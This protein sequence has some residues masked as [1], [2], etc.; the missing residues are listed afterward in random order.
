[1]KSSIGMCRDAMIHLATSLLPHND[2][3]IHHDLHT[4]QWKRINASAIWKWK[5]KE[6]TLSDSNYLK[7]KKRPKDIRVRQPIKRTQ[8]TSVSF[9][10]FYIHW[11]F[12][13]PVSPQ[14]KIYNDIIFITL[15]QKGIF[16]LM[17]FLLYYQSLGKEAMKLM[18][19]FN[20][21]L[22]DR[23]IFDA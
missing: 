19:V 8:I 6:K 23:L 2:T 1:M 11:C 3:Y 16:T 21:S 4:E 15:K 20:A 18:N 7:W 13:F 10:R 22:S 5:Q 14:P 9:C 17:V 12:F